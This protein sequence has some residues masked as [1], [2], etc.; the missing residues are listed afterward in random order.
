MRNITIATASVA[1]FVGTTSMAAQQTPSSKPSQTTETFGA[2]TIR[3]VGEEQK[4]CEALQVINSNAGT[5]AEIAIALGNNNKEAIIASRAPLGV[6]ISEPMRFGESGGKTPFEIN[7]V[8]CVSQG[9][10]AQ[11]KVS[12]DGLFELADKDAGSLT[13]K[14]RS[15]RALQIKLSLNGLKDA[16]IRLR[17]LG[18]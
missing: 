3:C 7:Y 6:M 8:T 4:S 5:I 2:W 13:F 10:I 11:T 14:E 9:C 1:L 16:L 18:A 17:A 12:T 15:G